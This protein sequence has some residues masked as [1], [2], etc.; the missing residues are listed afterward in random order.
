[1]LRC[2]P[3]D[4]SYYTLMYFYFCCHFH[5]LDLGNLTSNNPLLLYHS[6]FAFLIRHPS[7][8]PIQINDTTYR[9]R[10]LLLLVVCMLLSF[11]QLLFLLHIITCYIF[12]QQQLFHLISLES[13]FIHIIY[14]IISRFFQPSSGSR[15]L[16]VPSG[17]ELTTAHSKLSQN[18]SGALKYQQLRTA[19]G[20]LLW[21][22]FL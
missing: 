15:L 17:L 7:L 3:Y 10:H 6:I 5:K 13:F 18:Y 21:I 4:Q 14:V 22:I 12:L 8:L 9:L 11:R 19:G 20:E 16:P 1:M 2:K